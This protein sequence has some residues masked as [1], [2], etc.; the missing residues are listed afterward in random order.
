MESLLLVEDDAGVR[1]LTKRLLESA[2]YRVLAVSHPAEALLLLERSDE[3]DLLV[4]DIVMPGFSGRR[5]AELVQ[6]RNPRVKVLFL[7]G[8]PQAIA[9]ALVSAGNPGTWLFVQKPF[10]VADLSDMV[11]EALDLPASS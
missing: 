6:R 3:V 10:T 11:R 1:L 8:Y 4:T 2:G 5:L 7:S 9:R